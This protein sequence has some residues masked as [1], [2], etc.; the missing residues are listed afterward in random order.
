MP[1]NS[2][3]H[4]D[5][6]TFVKKCFKMSRLPIPMKDSQRSVNK[7]EKSSSEKNVLLNKSFHSVDIMK[8]ATYFH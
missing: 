7:H 1:G 2:V 3:T 8:S 5:S 6:N 4:A